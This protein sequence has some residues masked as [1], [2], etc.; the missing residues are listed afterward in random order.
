MTATREKE[1]LLSIGK[2]NSPEPNQ[3]ELIT[4]SQDMNGYVEKVEEWG[5]ESMIDEP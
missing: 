4:S 2:K 1:H 5:Q 3:E